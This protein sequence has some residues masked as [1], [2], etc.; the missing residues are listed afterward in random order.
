MDEPD[1]LT[2]IEALEAINANE[3][4]II[5]YFRARGLLDISPDPSS[6][7]ASDRML[8]KLQQRF[9]REIF[10]LHP[11]TLGSGDAIELHRVKQA[12]AKLKEF[13]RAPID[14]TQDDDS[15][16]SS[17]DEDNGLE[18]E[19]TTGRQ[20]PNAGALVLACNDPSPSLSSERGESDRAD[21]ATKDDANSVE[22]TNDPRYQWYIGKS[23]RKGF[24]FQGR[25]ISLDVG[26]MENGNE[27]VLIQVEFDNGDK[28]DYD[29]SEWQSELVL[30]NDST[31]ICEQYHP[32]G[33]I[34]WKKFVLEGQ[35]TGCQIG[36]P[37][38]IVVMLYDDDKN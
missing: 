9:K 10:S 30:D 31:S 2:V 19:T 8:R 12:W 33:A 3:P 22:D 17:N 15:E 21:D 34:V 6:K 37:V 1:E 11:D 16:T 7:W 14:L 32:L 18:G 23:V 35:V 20:S 25:V 4:H 26:R 36:E 27:G 28:E 13:Y 38:V 5:Q 24:W 29:Q